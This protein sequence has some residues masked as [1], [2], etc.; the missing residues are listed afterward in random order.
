MV[1]RYSK[2]ARTFFTKYVP[3]RSFGGH[4]TWNSA[5]PDPNVWCCILLFLCTLGST[6]VHLLCTMCTWFFFLLFDLH[7]P[8]QRLL[9]MCTMFGL[10]ILHTNSTFLCVY[11]CMYHQITISDTLLS[12]FDIGD[13]SKR[14][15]TPF[16][17]KSSQQRCGDSLTWGFRRCQNCQE[18]QTNSQEKCDQ[19]ATT[20]STARRFKPWHRCA[21]HGLQGRR[22]LFLWTER[23]MLL[24]EK[25]SR[26]C[27]TEKHF[28]WS[29]DSTLANLTG[30]SG[31]ACHALF[32]KHNHSLASCLQARQTIRGW[33]QRLLKL[34]QSRAKVVGC[35]Q[36]QKNDRELCRK[37]NALAE[38]TEALRQDW[39]RR[40]TKA[41]A[42]SVSVSASSTLHTSLGIS[43]PV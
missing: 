18:E 22:I 11:F 2:R 15:C 39:G 12:K 42:C 21:N 4:V 6:R 30:G 26:L 14:R 25:G 13:I 31:L 28:A 9:A 27:R 7:M 8:V 38:Y 20:H 32:T 43:Q 41:P 24:P 36:L 35:C 10:A 5:V 16:T 37:W 3:S 19:S 17:I 33:Q 40:P 29:Y 23:D 34:Q 1:F